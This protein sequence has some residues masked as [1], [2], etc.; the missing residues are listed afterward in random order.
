MFITTNRNKAKKPFKTNE[1]SHRLRNKY[2]Y[3]YDLSQ[4]IDINKDKQ[5]LQTQ[6]NVTYPFETM[7]EESNEDFLFDL[8]RRFD[9]IFKKLE[10]NEKIFE[11]LKRRNKHRKI[12]SEIINS[13][14]YARKISNPKKII[15]KPP[16]VDVNKI[17]EI[18][19]IFKGH[20]IRNIYLNVDRL[21]LRQ[22]L[23][24]LFCLLL[25]GHWCHAQKRYN[26]Y[27][28]KQYYITAKLYAGEEIS[29]IDRI[30]FKLPYCFYTGTKINNLRSSRIGEKLKIDD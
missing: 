14:I 27:L 12:S 9:D 24:E 30:A 29:F 17:I 18:Q 10:G 23:T 25:L 5:Y 16:K 21:K 28:M 8:W 7:D 15:R 11:Q 22:C 20:F 19:K 3:K 4:T 6:R 1:A 13:S 2:L 26:F